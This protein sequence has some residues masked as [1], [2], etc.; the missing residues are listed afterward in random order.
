MEYNTNTKLGLWIC[1]L[2]MLLILAVIL[3]GVFASVPNSPFDHETTKNVVH[4]NAKPHVTTSTIPAQTTAATTAK[5]ETTTETPI[6]ETEKRA[7]YYVTV[8]G[9][10]I[11]LLDEYGEFLQTLY[12]HASFLPKADLEAFRSGI[13]L[14]SKDDLNEMMDDLGA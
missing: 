3:A 8:S 13:E 12:A 9:D 1:F 4:A 6:M 5:Q 2:A 7:L 10:S 11:V 14:Y